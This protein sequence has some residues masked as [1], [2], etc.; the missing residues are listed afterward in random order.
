MSSRNPWQ[1]RPFCS[2]PCDACREWLQC[3]SADPTTAAAWKRMR[4]PSPLQ[5]LHTLLVCQK[6]VLNALRTISLMSITA[7]MNPTLFA[8]AVMAWAVG[9]LD[10]TGRSASS[11][12][13]LAVTGFRA[14]RLVQQ[15]QQHEDGRG[16][17]RQEQL[18]RHFEL[19]VSGLGPQKSAETEKNKLS[20]SV[21]RGRH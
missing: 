10:N 1:N 9:T 18:C 21:T 7:A 15:Q 11:L 6:C 14:S 20:S 8:L 19:G 3:W 4:P 12:V 16:H 5:S 2:L 13:M 17:R